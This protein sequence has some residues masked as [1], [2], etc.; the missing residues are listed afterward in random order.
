MGLRL[1]VASALV[2]ILSTW[3]V[4]GC[5]EGGGSTSAQEQCIATAQWEPQVAG[6]AGS[7]T[8]SDST[9]VREDRQVTGPLAGLSQSTLGKEIQ[10]TF[11]VPDLGANGSLTLEAKMTDFPSELSGSAYPVLVGLHDG[12]RDLI[13]LAR[14]GASGDCLAS[15]YFTCPSGTCTSNPS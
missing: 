5:S 10:V 14:T 3:L 15:G 12:T 13:N 4:V 2:L 6:S 11:D 1:W 7:A 8:V 9:I